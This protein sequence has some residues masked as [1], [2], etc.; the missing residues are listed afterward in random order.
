LRYLDE[1][2]GKNEQKS[3]C[4]MTRIR[5]TT[6][7]VITWGAFGALLYVAHEAFMATPTL[8]A[9]KVIAENIKS[10]KPVLEFLGPN[11]QTVGR[12]DK[13]KKLARRLEDRSPVPG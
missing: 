10:G 2:H 12:D 11:N 13:L 5:T 1:A 7:K 3:G 6:G 9:L 8:V 4:H